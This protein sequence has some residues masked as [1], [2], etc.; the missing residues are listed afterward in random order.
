ML[1]EMAAVEPTTAAS[2]RSRTQRLI[3]LDLSTNVQG[4]CN[5]QTSIIRY[6]EQC[7]DGW[8]GDDE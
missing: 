8:R 6:F 4:R 3:M 7:N 1:A 2:R 5:R